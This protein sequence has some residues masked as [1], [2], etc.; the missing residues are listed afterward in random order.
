[1]EFLL[2]TLLRNADEFVTD[3]RDWATAYCLENGLVL[4]LDESRLRASHRTWRATLTRWYAEGYVS[5]ITS[6]EL[7]MRIG[8]DEKTRFADYVAA[9]FSG[10]ESTNSPMKMCGALVHALAARQP[11]VFLVTFEEAA[12]IPA[13]RPL[14]AHRRAPSH[15]THLLRSAPDEV[16]AFLYA[17]KW[18]FHV[19]RFRQG[20]SQRFD[21]SR[22]PMTRHFL[23]NACSLIQSGDLGPRA[24]YMI[25]KTFDLCAIHHP[26]DG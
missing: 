10:A 16:L 13:L 18:L 5:D 8:R 4:H 17:H 15:P 7:R 26:L 22:P 12:R 20:A 24:L 9:D 6:P 1:M 23:W 2:K 21:L 19:E 3:F 25:F 11:V 14:V